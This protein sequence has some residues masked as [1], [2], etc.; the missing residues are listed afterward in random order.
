MAM[1]RYQEFCDSVD[2]PS[3]PPELGPLLEAL[4]WDRKGDWNKA[5]E[6]AQSIP[7]AEG[8]LVHA[9]LHRVEGDL[10]NA[11]YWYSRAGAPEY[12]G[13]LESEWQHRVEQFL[14]EA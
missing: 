3:P 14:K 5:H 4:W 2:L 7:S 11:R 12:T 8:S 10:W 9:Y 6:I 1:K 13:T